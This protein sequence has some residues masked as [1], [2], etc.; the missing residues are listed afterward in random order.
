MRV[1]YSQKSVD[2][3]SENLQNQLRL[4][5]FSL[6]DTKKFLTEKPLYLEIGPGKGK[7]ILELASKNKDKNFLVVELNKTIAGY[8]LKAIDKSELDNVKLVANDFYKLVDLL[9]EESIEGIFLNF[10]DPWP[11]KRHEKRRLTSDNFFKAYYK[12]LK[13]NHHIYFKSDNFDFYKFSLEQAI[14]FNYEITYNNNDYKEED[15]FDSMTEYE[16]KYINKGIKINRMILKKTEETL[17][18]VKQ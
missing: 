12:V 4:E 18:E 14:K 1:K 10:S 3:L 15:D 5:D 9:D 11:K 7:F 2:Y 16:A 13:N 8:C 6:E 17:N